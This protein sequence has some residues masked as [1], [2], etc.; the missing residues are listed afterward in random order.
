VIFYAKKSGNAKA[1]YRKKVPYGK[2]P[3]IVLHVRDSHGGVDRYAQRKDEG[4]FS[5]RQGYPF[6]SAYKRKTLFPFAEVTHVRLLL[7]SAV[8]LYHSFY[9]K[10]NYFTIFSLTFPNILAI[11][12]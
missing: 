10:S 5:L 8:L 12:K 2:I 9:R 7:Y 4:G 6:V 1:R 11:I 3:P